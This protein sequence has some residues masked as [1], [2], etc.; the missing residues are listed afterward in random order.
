MDI[1]HSATGHPALSATL[2]AVEPFTGYVQLKTFFPLLDF[3][4]LNSGEWCFDK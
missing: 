3:S 1:H 4:F 2:G